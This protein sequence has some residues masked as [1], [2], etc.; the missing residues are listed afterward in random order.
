MYLYLE[1]LTER[2]LKNNPFDFVIIFS[3]KKKDQNIRKIIFQVNSSSESV[4]ILVTLFLSISQII[5][6]LKLYY[7]VSIIHLEENK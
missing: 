2:F 7:T 4:S 6:S 3:Q 5:Y 1:S